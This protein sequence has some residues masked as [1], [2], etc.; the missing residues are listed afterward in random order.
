MTAGGARFAPLDGLGG[1]EPGEPVRPYRYPDRHEGWIVTGYAQARA[2][3]GEPGF[4][5][6]AE[7]KRVPVD[8]PGAEPFIGQAAPPGWFIDLDPPEHTRYRRVL[9]RWF[10][11]HRIERLRP[12]IERIVAEHLEIVAGRP[13]PV[14]LV[15]TFAFPV[16]LLV[17]CQLLGVP[18]AS[19]ELLRRHST[20]L[21][22]LESTAAEGEAAMGELTSLFRE[23]VAHKRRRPGDDVLSAL[24]AEFSRDEAAGA[25][26]LL[27]TAGHE[28]VASML[29]LGILTLL[30]APAHRAALRPG[31][32]EAL[33]EELLRHLSILHLGVPRGAGRDTILGGRLIRAG[34]SLTVSLPAANRDPARFARPGVCDPARGAAG[35]LAFGFGVHQCVGANLARVQLGVAYPAIFRRFPTLRLAVGADQVPITRHGAVYG[36]ARLPVAW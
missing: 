26:V 35:H 12:R 5:S 14:D 22:S 13:Q 31:A 34:D 36:A 18:Y 16:P 17:I 33:V 3:L 29:G 19:R 21:F 6:R 4:S 24:A 30:D 11:M 20:A 27:L 9:A 1:G 7:G 2:V 23:L 28:T 8:R 25:G 32:V 10:N 15:E